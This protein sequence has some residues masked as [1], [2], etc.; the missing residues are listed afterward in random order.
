MG[1][2]PWV[3]GGVRSLVVVSPDP[4]SMAVCRAG[5]FPFPLGVGE[6]LS[7]SGGK[8]A[9]KGASRNLDRALEMARAV[10]R[11][12]T[13][14]GWLRHRMTEPITWVLAHVSWLRTRPGPV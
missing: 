3:F 9:A 2:G 10:F 12:C 7:I 11:A 13:F 5:A 4:N 6:P 1:L 8:P 14:S